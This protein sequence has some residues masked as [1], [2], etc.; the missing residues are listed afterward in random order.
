MIP[1]TPSYH[2]ELSCGDHAHHDGLLTI[3]EGTDDQSTN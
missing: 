3:D 1:A 2:I